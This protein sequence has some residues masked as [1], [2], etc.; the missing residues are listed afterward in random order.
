MFIISH[1][2]CYND[3][4]MGIIVN[5][6]D[7]LDNELS[8]RIDADLRSK[9]SGNSRSD[10]VEQVDFAEG[11][12]YAEDLKKTSRFGWFWVILIFAAIVA[13]IAVVFL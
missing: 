3:K 12:R 2:L 5:K 6:D 4:K 1:F 10:D 13:L 7:K 11:A 9:L 8:R